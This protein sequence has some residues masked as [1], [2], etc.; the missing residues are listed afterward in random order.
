M[1]LLRHVVTLVK[2][3]NK[4]KVSF[5]LIVTKVFELERVADMQYN[6]MPIEKI[7]VFVSKYL[8]DVKESLQTM[9]SDD[10][11]YYSKEVK[12]L[13]VQL[14]DILTMQKNGSYQRIGVFRQPTAKGSIKEQ[15]EMQESKQ[16]ILTVIHKNLKFTQKK[17]EDFGYTISAEAKT[18]VYDMVQVLNDQFA[19]IS[20]IKKE[21]ESQ[22][23][24]VEQSYSNDFSF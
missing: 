7:V 1:Q 16:Q 5:A 12:V 14:I 11:Q 23:D 6:I 24:A 18:R 19:D 15:V 9:H 21:F 10:G 2:D 4:F 17:V 22:L 13:A 3:V 8:T 20:L